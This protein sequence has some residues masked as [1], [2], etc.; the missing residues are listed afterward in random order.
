MVR[1]STKK[2]VTN[3]KRISGRKVKTNSNLAQRKTLT[4]KEIEGIQ[5]R[6][7]RADKRMTRRSQSAVTRD[8]QETHKKTYHIDERG[9]WGKWV[10]DPGTSDIYGIDTA[11]WRRE[12]RNLQSRLTR[13]MNRL[14]AEKKPT[15]RK[16][17]I[18][19]E[20]KPK[21]KRKPETK[22]K[23]IQKTQRKL[24]KEIKPQAIIEPMPKKRGLWSF[25]TDLLPGRAVP[26]KPLT[27]NL[28]DKTIKSQYKPLMQFAKTEDVI[29]Q[30]HDETGQDKKDIE[31]F[32][33]Q[34]YLNKELN[35]MTGKG[36]GIQ[37][38]NTKFAF[39][40]VRE[41]TVEEKAEIQEYE[42]VEGEPTPAYLLEPQTSLNTIQNY[43]DFIEKSET[44]SDA[45]FED[46]WD[47]LND[48][49]NKIFEFE[50]LTDRELEFFNSIKQFEKS[51]I[52][53]PLPTPEVEIF[54]EVP[55]EALVTEEELIQQEIESIE[56]E[57][58]QYFDS[59]NETQTEKEFLALAKPYFTDN[60]LAKLNP[61]KRF[62]YYTNQ[63]EKV[64]GIKD[65]ELKK[66]VIDEV[67]RQFR[68]YGVANP[69]LIEDRINLED[70]II[71]AEEA[72]AEISA[73]PPGYAEQAKQAVQEI[74]PEEQPVIEEIEV[75]PQKQLSERATFIKGKSLEEIQKYDLKMYLYKQGVILDPNDPLADDVVDK[76]Y[77]P[78][79]TFSEMKEEALKQFDSSQRSKNQEYSVPRDLAIE[80]FLDLEEKD[81][82]KDLKKTDKKL[83]PEPV[84]SWLDNP[85]KSDVEDLDTQVDD[86]KLKLD[87]L[88]QEL[89][90]LR[91]LDQSQN[92]IDEINREITRI[93]NL[94]QK[95]GDW[96]M[97][98]TK[99]EIERNAIM[100]IIDPNFEPSVTR[101]QPNKEEMLTVLRDLTVEKSQVQE[102]IFGNVPITVDD[103]L[104]RLD[105][106]YNLDNLDSK[107]VKN[108]LMELVDAELIDI[109]EGSKD[110]SEARVPIK[111]GGETRFI[112][113]L[114]LREKLND[115]PIPVVADT[116]IKVGRND[117]IH[118]AKQMERIKHLKVAVIDFEELIKDV[119]KGED[120]DDDEKTE[121]NLFSAIG[122]DNAERLTVIM[123]RASETGVTLPAKD[124]D[125]NGN[126]T[127]FDDIKDLIN[128]LN[129]A[130]DT[131]MDELKKA[132]KEFNDMRNEPKPL[133]PKYASPENPSGVDAQTYPDLYDDKVVHYFYGTPDRIIYEYSTRL[134]EN[135]IE[136]PYEITIKEIK[137]RFGWDKTHPDLAIYDRTGKDR[138]GEL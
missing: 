107:E 91:S 137:E 20:V 56:K 126:F 53:E 5:S 73:L 88:K 34:L 43:R 59:L 78:Q 106:A 67:R 46:Q 111:I 18:V 104:E 132:Q 95:P 127:T 138:S 94:D 122:D 92:R 130:L 4:L 120:I 1:T 97:Q 47:L 125:I 109:W 65:K 98:I 42:I 7:E 63:L 9:K 123:E 105:Q 13:A 60:E 2:K 44:I 83:F 128:D 57:E 55:E 119:E 54:E 61:D 17:K 48:I 27:K 62:L 90:D 115:K 69:I 96:E 93:E 28:V 49:Q 136:Q 72:E 85:L 23:K 86:P 84:T 82:E 118:I 133:P 33:R 51:Q 87:L 89:T 117:S 36:K 35:L 108:D 121:T 14:Q 37:V 29:N 32:M 71:E 81:K 25:L 30:I 19:K 112:A 38:D 70:A 40:D 22:A 10:R 39:V 64:K 74:L 100:G 135:F 129:T 31:E 79:L 3:K 21:R 116:L 80:R 50:D 75:K 52:K 76:V 110:V 131:R 26:K 113:W 114:Q 16:P 124:Y 58:Q 68:S 99:L 8:R 15:K 12:R 77:D 45:Q 41:P 66:N 103:F 24:R 102:H 101:D 11:S 134:D 6:I